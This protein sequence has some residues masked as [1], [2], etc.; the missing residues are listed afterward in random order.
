VTIGYWAPLPPART[1]VSDY[2]AALLEAMRR[3]APVKVNAPGDIDLYQMGNNQL[4]R[5]IYA[6]ALAHPGV[7]IL[8]DAVLQHFMLGSLTEAGYVAE[9]RYNY[10]EWS[11]ET[12][13][14][15]WATRSRSASDPAFFR[16]P[17]LRRLAERSLAIIVHNPAAAA[18]VRNHSSTA[19][20]SII[21]HLH[22]PQPPP[23]ACDVS[24]LRAEL[25]VPAHE[26]LLGV[27][28]HL[29][30]SKR[31]AS[32]LRAFRIAREVAP[33]RLLIAG[34]FVSAD[35]ARALEPLLATAGVIRRP[36]LT[37]AAFLLHAAATD[38]CISLRYPSAGETSGITVVLMGLDKP[39]L[40]T[41]SPEN[42]YPTDACIRVSAGLSEE[43][44]LTA[45]IIALAARSHQARRIGENAAAFIA[46]E[47]DPNRAALTCLAILRACY[48]ESS[49]PRPVAQA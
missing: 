39:V 26:F 45:Q 36:H 37:D 15:L 29:R 49:I 9:F 1:G 30:E 28:G 5:Q 43:E 34:D 41:D 31:I 13:R 12:A 33:V 6:R 22:I 17:M 44:E 19:R 14:R 40:L 48:D 47:H 8:H 16:Y 27:F 10:G 2:A 32:V 38:A 7:V 21:R 24:R 20:V 4:H 46:T 11:E 25:G 35:Y 23:A 18:M 42:D 3:H